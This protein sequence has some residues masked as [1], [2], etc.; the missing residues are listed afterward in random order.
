MVRC[1]PPQP[2]TAAHE[3]IRADEPSDLSFPFEQA[4]TDHR[5]IAQNEG[6]QRNLLKDRTHRASPQRPHPQHKVIGVPLLS[7]L[8]FLSCAS[9]ELW[10]NCSNFKRSAGS[11]LPSIS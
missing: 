3:Q 11:K 7:S 6:V 1:K 2:D 8:C 9:I 4:E 5:L 10:M